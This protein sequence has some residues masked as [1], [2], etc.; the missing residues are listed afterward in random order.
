MSCVGSSLLEWVRFLEDFLPSVRL[1]TLFLS[2]ST[3]DSESLDV[4]KEQLTG[5]IAASLDSFSLEIFSSSCVSGLCVSA[6]RPCVYR[7]LQIFT[8]SVWLNWKFS[9]PF[10]V[11]CKILKHRCRI[12]MYNYPSYALTKAPTSCHLSTGL[13]LKS[14][15]SCSFTNPILVAPLLCSSHAVSILDIIQR[16]QYS[17]YSRLP[18]WPHWIFTWIQ[19]LPPLPIDFILTKRLWLN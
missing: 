17:L 19:L 14:E 16:P 3:V 15:S 1:Q 11:I 12:Y 6:I 4:G 2:D 10:D 8:Y 18:V 7:F 9:L 5:Q 13:S